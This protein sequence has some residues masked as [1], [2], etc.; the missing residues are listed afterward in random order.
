M[1]L[2]GIA[3]G[4]GAAVHQQAQDAAIVVGRA[5]DQKVVGGV[6]P[7]LSQPLEIRLESAGRGDERPGAH[8]LGPAG[9]R[10]EGGGEAPVADVQPGHPGVV[11]DGDA[12]A[13]GGAIVAVHQRLA[14]A[15]K[16]GIRAREV[17]RAAERRLKAGAVADHPVPA[18]GRLADHDPR[19]RFVGPAAGHPGEIVPVFRLGVGVGQSIG[20][21]LVHAA[22]VPGVPAVA[23][24]EVLRSR[25]EH[26]HARAGGPGGKGR[27]E[28]GV[29]A[30]D[31][32]HVDVPKHGADIRH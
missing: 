15:E 12:E 2:G 21:G 31:H 8:L 17:E 4:L 7:D 16:E 26:Q 13:L 9:S 22:Q 30:A 25:F 18:G 32:Q 6:A 24:P 23:T 1:A 10:D 19:E 27:A 3:G 11:L 5:A 29:A 28:P 20:G 14:A